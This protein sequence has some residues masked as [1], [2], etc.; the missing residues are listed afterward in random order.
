MIDKI[1]EVMELRNISISEL[2]R[3][4]P[5]KETTRRK[6][7]S[8]VLNRRRDPGRKFLEEISFALMLE[9]DLVGPHAQK[10]LG[11]LLDKTGSHKKYE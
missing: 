3:M 11:A 9:W 1:K 6:D 8:E 2:A 4:L 10:G 7:L 5:G